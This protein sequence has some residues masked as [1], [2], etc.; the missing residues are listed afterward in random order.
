M[1]SVYQRFHNATL[2]NENI[3]WGHGFTQLSI[4]SP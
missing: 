1:N 3:A 4:V 2:R